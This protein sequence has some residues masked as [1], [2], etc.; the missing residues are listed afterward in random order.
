[1]A[2]VGLAR[3]ILVGLIIEPEQ[4]KARVASGQASLTTQPK[5]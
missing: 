4:A 5:S 2:R 1:M 3:T